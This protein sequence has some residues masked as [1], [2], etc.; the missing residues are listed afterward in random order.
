MPVG[1]PPPPLLEWRG[2]N[3][4]VVARKDSRFDK[5][6]RGVFRRGDCPLYGARGESTHEG[7]ADHGADKRNGEAGKGFHA[8]ILADCGTPS[9]V[10]SRQGK[11]G[12]QVPRMGQNFLA[13]F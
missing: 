6:R 8:P 2:G 3:F 1:S 13:L 4:S 5:N 12:A 9:K 11:K 10:F 7:C